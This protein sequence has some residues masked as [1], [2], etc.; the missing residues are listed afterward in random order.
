M[1]KIGIVNFIRIVQMIWFNKMFKLQWALLKGITDNGINRLKMI[2]NRIDTSWL[3]LSKETYKHKCKKKVYYNT[4]G[5]VLVISC[6]LFIWWITCDL[7]VKLSLWPFNMLCIIF[8][9]CVT[10]LVNKL[11]Q[12]NYYNTMVSNLSW[13][14]SPKFN[15]QT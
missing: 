14:V 13:V 12:Y 6:Q 3:M 7:P 5:S 9:L 4:L 10:C 1:K 2:T 11:L 15:F 8:I